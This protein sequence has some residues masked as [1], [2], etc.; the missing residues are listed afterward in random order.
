MV[1]ESYGYKFLRLN[2]FNLGRDPI[3]SL[4]ERLHALINAA[5][6]EIEPKAV[7]KIRDVAEDLAKGEAKHC[8]KCDQVKPLDAFFDRNLKGGK[9][10]YGQICKDCKLKRPRTRKSIWGRRRWRRRYY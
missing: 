2:R 7:A 5:A 9:G 6:N 10:G 8:R 4:S 3:Q 1:I